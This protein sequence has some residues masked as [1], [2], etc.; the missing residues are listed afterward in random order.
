MEN[1][2]VI[3]MGGSIFDS[4]DTTITDMVSLQ[5]QGKSLVVVHG[6]GNMVTD[7]LKR[8]KVATRFIHGERAT[9]DASLEVSVAVL[10]GLANKEIV[11]AINNNGGRATGISGVDGALIQCRIKNM[12]LGFVGEVEKVDTTL[13]DALLKAGYIV[14][15]S[16][17]SLHVFDKQDD[18]PNLLNVNGDVVAGEIAAAIGAER[19]VFLTDV[20][21]ICGESGNLLAELS[22]SEAESLINSGVAS[23]GMI[24]KIKACLKALTSITSARIIDGRQ[25][26]ALMNELA[27]QGGGTA[28]HK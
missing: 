14:V 8:Q 2:I 20:A 16:P 7:W 21:G 18:A 17:I 3:K 1:V 9:D 13:L 27:G 24:P 4:G 11:A 15:V 19:L 23:G 10:S 6:G 25:S 26:H 5:Q 28:I 12:E 22:A